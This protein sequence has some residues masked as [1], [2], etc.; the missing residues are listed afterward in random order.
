MKSTPIRPARAAMW[1]RRA[2]RR[3]SSSF[4]VSRR[5][6][7]SGELVTSRRA[8]SCS[9]SFCNAAISPSNTC[10]SVS[11]ILT[12]LTDGPSNSTP[13]NT[14][15]VAIVMAA[16]NCSRRLRRKDV[17]RGSQGHSITHASEAAGRKTRPALSRSESQSRRDW[18]N[19]FLVA[20]TRVAAEK[21]GGL[22][23]GLQGTRPPLLEI[24]QLPGS[25]QGYPRRSLAG[26]SLRTG[27]A[28]H[29]Q[30]QP[31]SARVGFQTIGRPWSGSAPS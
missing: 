26:L 6:S 14:M 25:E 5:D 10:R 4:T 11:S 20:S 8:P 29:H 15:L 12:R 2:E 1:V 3:G 17:S 21:N 23:Q 13:T 24:R 28:T 22:F 27:Q 19:R 30:E 31:G 7:D 18:S 9:S 16:I